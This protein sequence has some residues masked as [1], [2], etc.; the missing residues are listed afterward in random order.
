[1]AGKNVGT[2]MQKLSG[3]FLA[4]G[5]LLVIS[6]FVIMLFPVAGTFAVEILFGILLLVGG[7]GQVVMAFLARKWSGFF[8]TLLTGLLYT[9]AGLLLLFYPLQGEITLTLLLGVFLLVTGV[10]KMA[11][12]SKLKPRMHYE[13]LLFDGIITILLGFLILMK[14]PSDSLWV[15]GLLFGI[16]VLFSGLSFLMLSFA[17]GKS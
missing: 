1:M 11:L 2:E 14:W 12:S 15:I 3:W 8:L 7:I 16:N 6:G 13:W 9:V 5:V 17:S 10:L 4:L